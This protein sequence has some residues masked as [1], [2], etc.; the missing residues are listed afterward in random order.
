MVR[1]EG[2]EDGAGRA[3]NLAVRAAA[4]RWPRRPAGAARGGGGAIEIRKRI[5]VAAGLAGGSADAAAA[6]VACNE[7]W[8]TG[9][10][11]AE[12]SEVAAG[13]GSDVPF[14]LHGGTAVGVGRGEQLTPVLAAGKYHWV[15]AFAAG[16]LSTPEVYAA[17]DRLRAARSG[18]GAGP[19]PRMPTWTPS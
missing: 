2:A 6:L 3:S 4:A 13:L 7:L 1:G 5:P 12:L 11:T 16:G 17:C 8:Q 9:C 10:T 15:L 18:G 14:S 19:V